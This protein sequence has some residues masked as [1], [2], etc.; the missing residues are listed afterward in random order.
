MK[1][2]SLYIAL[3][4]LVVS[5]ILR[6][7]STRLRHYRTAKRLG[8]EPPNKYPHTLPLGYDLYRKLAEARINGRRNRFDL[9]LFRR[10]G[11]TFEFNSPQGK[12]I[13]TMET[14]NFQAI[15]TNHFPDFGREARRPTQPFFGEG[16]FNSNGAVWKRARE[17]VVPLF[18]RAELNDVV[19]IARAKAPQ[20]ARRLDGFYM[21]CRPSNT[22]C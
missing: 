7:L 15:A 11:S 12:V 14:R 10:Y 1:F 6:S 16:I 8:C 13:T 17:T 20:R 4:V 5:F 9:E 2:L 18:K 19:R 22:T 3:T 21:L